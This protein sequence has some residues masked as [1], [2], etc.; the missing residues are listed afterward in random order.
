MTAVRDSKSE[1]FEG[2]MR[3]RVFAVRGAAWMIRRLERGLPREVV[4]AMRQTP[5]QTGLREF[6]KALRARE[7]EADREA[8]ESDADAFERLAGVID[9]HRIGWRDIDNS[10]RSEPN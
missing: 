10:S 4:Q 8:R 1:V 9:H 5:P 2:M 6:S 3:S 7:G